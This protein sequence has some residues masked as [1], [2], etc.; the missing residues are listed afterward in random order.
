[1]EIKLALLG[2]AKNLCLLENSLYKI[3][4][5]PI[6]Q[7]SNYLSQIALCIE[8]GLK[9][10]IINTDDFEHEHNLE[11]LYSMTPTTFQNKFKS[12][13]SDNETF[14]RN[15]SN[16][17]NIFMDFR[18]MKHESTLREYHDETILNSDGTIN[19]RKAT[20]LTEFQFLIMLR[21]EIFNYEDFIREEFK[22]QSRNID[23]TDVD[24]IISRYTEIAKN[25]QSKIK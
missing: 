23:L 4:N 22:K 10:I 21:E 20:N 15:M 6:Y 12:C 2:T 24:F 8:L 11:Y 19:L 17:K 3:E 18:Y 16:I 1:M 5:I 7:Y 25:I 14:T 13:C 9:S